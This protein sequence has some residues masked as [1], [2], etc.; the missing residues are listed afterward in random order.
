MVIGTPES[1]AQTIAISGKEEFDGTPIWS[2]CGRFVAARTRS[3]VEIRN[4]LTLELI[5]ILQ[6][7]EMILNLRGPLAYSPDGRSIA[8][9][10]DTTVMIWDIQTGGVAKEIKRRANTTSLVWSPDGRTICTVDLEDRRTFAVHI[11]DVPSGTI[12]SPGT[13]RSEHDPHLWMVDR[14]FRVM[15]TTRNEYHTDAFTFDIFEVGS[16]LT[17]IHSFPLNYLD[18]KIISFSPTTHHVSISNGNMLH[19][20]DTRSFRRYLREFGRFLSCCFS[21][22]GSLFA[23]SR[24][25]MVRVW[26]HNSGRYTLYREFHCRDLYNP[27]RFSPT[28]SSI[29]GHSKDILRVWR[30]HRLHEFP[31]SLKTSSQQYVG[32]SRSGT[33]VAIAHKMERTVTIVDLLAQTP[34]QFI[35]VG[36]AIQGFVL[37]GNVLL[38]TGS[39][40]VVAWLLTEEGLVDGFIGDRRVSCE[41][42]IWNV[43]KSASGWGINGSWMLLVE[44]QVGVV[45]DDYRHSRTY[46]TETGKLLRSARAPQNFGDRWRALGEVFCSWGYPPHT[47]S[48]DNAPPEGMWQT[49]QATLRNGW[50]KD[51]EGKHRLWVP[52]EW[53]TDWDPADWCHDVTIQLGVLEGR[54]VLIKF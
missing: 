37:T 51:P 49:S 31:T 48:Q 43:S 12:S 19:I 8:C 29:L 30:L 14:S 18:P 3:A 4:Q 45:G 21:S 25:D 1:W 54:I 32:L 50:V 42:S 52:V 46:H 44:G 2:P 16:T 23:A 22:D 36:M 35:D 33:R 39:D 28:P 40:K 20:S 11:Y 6:P 24:E 53:R 15:T 27:L 38:V 26:K 10:S 34:L 47:L 17:W 7:T 41:N 13:A 9:A 5:T